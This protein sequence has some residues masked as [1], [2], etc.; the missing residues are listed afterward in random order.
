M[1]TNQ[2][3]TGDESIEIWVWI[4]R[5]RIDLGT[6]QP[7]Y[8]YYPVPTQSSQSVAL[9]S[10]HK[11]CSFGGENIPRAKRKTYR[12]SINTQMM[13]ISPPSYFTPVT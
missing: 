2:L 7:V 12:C 13:E 10:D 8:V 1:G 5:V 4:N 11:H 6:T 3:N 9:G